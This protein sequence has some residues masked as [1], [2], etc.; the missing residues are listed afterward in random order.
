MLGHY[1]MDPKT[2]HAIV[3]LSATNSD[4]AVNP[5]IRLNGIMVV[6]LSLSTSFFLLLRLM[7]TN[8]L[9]IDASIQPAHLYIKASRARSQ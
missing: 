6:G 8:V 4:W 1:T 3:Y 2:I 7:P 5:F 9:G